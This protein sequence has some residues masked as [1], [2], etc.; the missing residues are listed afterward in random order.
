MP[1]HRKGVST[2]HPK[3]Y[4]DHDRLLT[5]KEAALLAT[6]WRGLYSAGTA[7]VSEAAI[8]QWRHRGQLNPRGLTPHG[9]ALYHR[10]D[11]AEAERAARDIALNP[12]HALRLAGISTP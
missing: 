3:D 6:H 9:R 7:T 5:T 2:T 4:D 10:D 8:R 12:H 1:A 11:L